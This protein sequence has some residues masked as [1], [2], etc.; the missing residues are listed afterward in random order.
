LIFLSSCQSPTARDIAKYVGR[1][2]LEIPC[3]SNGDGT[4]VINGE[5]RDLTPGM[6]CTD[7]N[8]FQDMQNHLEMMEFYKYKCKKFGRCK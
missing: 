1:P 2:N 4:C 5:L 6:L 8:N 3:I 7:T